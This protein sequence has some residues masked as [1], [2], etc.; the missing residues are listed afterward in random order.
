MKLVNKLFVI[1]LGIATLTSCQ[2]GLVWDDV[3]TEVY[4]NVALNANLCKIE[5][6]EIFNKKVFQ[7]NY[8]QWVE[9]MLLVSNIGTA[10]QSGKDY[11]NNTGADVNILG[12]VVKPGETINVKN[13]LTTIDEASAPDGKVYVVNVFAD[14][15]ALYRTPNKGHLFVESAFQGDAV[16]P[17]FGTLVDE[18]RYQDATLPVDITKLSVGLLLDNSR[19]CEVEKVNNAPE[20]GIPGDF[21][22]PQRY[23]VVNITRRPDGEPAAR[24]L[25]EIRVQLLK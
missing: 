20:L 8:N 2:K 5:T 7:V 25:Y 18:G 16:K 13:R 10:Y 22:Q 23:M 4:N 3:P 19:T 11:T 9:N 1:A 6:R 21:T 15:K 12:T 14:A 24:R 17:E